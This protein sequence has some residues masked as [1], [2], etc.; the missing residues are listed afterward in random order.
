MEFDVVV[1]G[2][3]PAGLAAAIRLMQLR[4]GLQVAV[5]E[6]GAEV[7]AHILSGAVIDPVG[8]DALPPRLARRGGA[9]PHARHRAALRLADRAS[10]LCAT[11]AAA[12]AGDGQSRQFHRLAGRGLPVAGRQGRRRSGAQI[13]PGFAAVEAL[14]DAR[15]AM[16]GVAT[17]DMGRGRDGRPKPGFQPGIELRARY[18]LIAEGARG[19]LAKQLIARFGLAEGRQPQKYGIGLKE[20]W[21][22]RR[23]PPPAGPGAAQLRLAAR[24]SRRRRR[25]PHHMGRNR[26][27]ARP[28]GASRL[29]GIRICRRSASSSGSRRILRSPPC[30]PAAGASAMARGRSRKAAGSR[31]RASSFRAGR[32]SAAP[33]AS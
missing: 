9:R 7:G 14:F 21:E 10:R 22:N 28:G 30:S 19:S 1:V 2:A 24:R 26:V 4:P 3:G 15:G 8:L 32:W 16:L 12:A 23:S 33:P 6:K 11:G 18:T 29:R 25:L 20:L 5:L 31:C 27:V 17:G 13:F